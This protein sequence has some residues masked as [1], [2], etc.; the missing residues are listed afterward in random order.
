MNKILYQPWGGLG[1]NLQYSTLPEL[2]AK[3]GFD[4]YISEK[5]VYRNKEIYELVWGPNPYVKGISNEKPNVGSCVRLRRIPNKSTVYG[6]ELSH[7]FEPENEIPKIYY[8]PKIIEEMSDK[9]FVDFSAISAWPVI[10]NDFENILKENESKVLIP[11]FK[12]FCGKQRIN[13]NLKYDSVIEIDS[14]FHYT[15]CVH[16]CKLF[17]C[18]FSGQS[19]LA[20]AIDKKDTLCLATKGYKNSHFV[21]PNI[22]YHFI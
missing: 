18:S 19:V 16:S 10:P 9:V 11:H 22:K 20:S 6:Y 14:I 3:K 12:N 8:K 13:N 17:I 15:D 4:F 1:D 2:F 7:G 21:F 5:N